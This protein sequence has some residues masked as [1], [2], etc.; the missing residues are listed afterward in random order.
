MLWFYIN[1]LSKSAPKMSSEVTGSSLN[2]AR[3]RSGRLS[4]RQTP[5]LSSGGFTTYLLLDGSAA[6]MSGLGCAQCA[7]P[8]GSGSGCNPHD[9]SRALPPVCLCVCA[10]CLLVPYP[11]L[12]ASLACCERPLLVLCPTVRSIGG[13]APPA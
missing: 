4:C 1:I 8:M 9:W 7:F 3:T 10:V 2:D 12:T 6:G 5:L 13:G 11:C